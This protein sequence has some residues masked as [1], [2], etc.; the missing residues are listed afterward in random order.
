VTS[1]TGFG[2]DDDFLFLMGISTGVG[3]LEDRLPCERAASV[4]VERFPF[5]W[6][7]WE[8]FSGKRNRTIFLGQNGKRR[9]C[10]FYT[11]LRQK[12]VKPTKF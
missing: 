6:K 5:V 12:N 4:D 7:N 3:N 10:S 11:E 2:T 1:S 8:E 9:A